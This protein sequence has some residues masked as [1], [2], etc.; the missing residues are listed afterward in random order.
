MLINQLMRIFY[1]LGWIS[2]STAEINYWNQMAIE[3]M[4]SLVNPTGE[5]DLGSIDP[6][7]LRKEPSMP[8]YP[9]INRI[10][11]LYETRKAKRGF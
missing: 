8:V 10:N 9:L 7:T 1:E 6:D 3:L 5:I 2:A 11:S 4:A